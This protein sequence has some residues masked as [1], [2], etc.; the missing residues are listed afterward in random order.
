MD[1][2]LP[3]LKKALDVA[4]LMGFSEDQLKQAFTRAGVAL[5]GGM[6]MSR[7][8]DRSDGCWLG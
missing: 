5:P 6:D 3:R 2:A 8:T 1:L 7:E 4:L